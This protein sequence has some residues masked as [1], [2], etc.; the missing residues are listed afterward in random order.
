MSVASAE[1]INPPVLNAVTSVSIAGGSASQIPYQSAPNTTAFLPNGTA[2]QVLTSAGTTLPP[3]WTT[4]SGGGTTLPYIAFSNPAPVVY[5]TNNELVYTSA[6]LDAGT[7][8]ISAHGLIEF[9]SGASTTPQTALITVTDNPATT[10]NEV[11]NNFDFTN[12]NSIQ[13][14]ALQTYSVSTTIEIYIECF[15]YTTNW[16]LQ[17]LDVSVVRIA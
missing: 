6:S 8:L 3:T 15:D 5:T 14:T 17:N 2:G 9:T 13:I 11:E 16:T 12:G 10:Q 1:G 7:Y 4:P